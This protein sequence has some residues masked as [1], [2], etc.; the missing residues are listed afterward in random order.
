MFP[1]RSYS[2]QAKTPSPLPL[3]R[4]SKPDPSSPYSPEFTRSSH[5]G[6]MAGSALNSPN[7]FD[8]TPPPP[9]H[10]NA[11][12]STFL[13]GSKPGYSLV[14]ER[15]SSPDGPERPS[16]DSQIGQMPE[17]EPAY[18]SRQQHLD[19]GDRWV[20]R[21]ELHDPQGPQ[22]G[23]L[24]AKAAGKQPV[25]SNSESRPQAEA[26]MGASRAEVV[27]PGGS[28]AD[29]DLFGT[30][31][32]TPRA[33]M[34]R[35]QSTNNHKDES[36][37]SGPPSRAIRPQSHYR[38]DSGTPKKMTK[39]QFESLR[40]RADPEERHEEANAEDEP[41][42]ED[43]DERVRKIAAQRKRQEATMSVYRQQMK[44]MTG[45]QPADLPSTRPGL[46]RH[47]VSAPMAGSMSSLHLGGI[48]NEPQMN[49]YRS[50]HSDDEDDEVPLG[51]LQA[52]GFPNGTKPPTRADGMGGPPSAAPSVAGGGGGGALPAF[53]RKLPAD[54]YY[55]AGLVNQSNREGL[56]MNGSGSTYGGASA[57]P[58]GLGVGHP[59]G[60]VGVI[61]GEERAKAAR[62]ATPSGSYSS[63]QPLPS[64]M[65]Q[66]PSHMPRTMSMG[67]VQ[68]QA[69]AP[70]GM[71]PM[72]PMPGM[73]SMMQINPQDQTQAQ[74]QQL[75]H[76]QMQFMQKMMAMQN[77][78]MPPMQNQMSG[79]SSFLAPPQL[80]QQQQQFPGSRPMSYAPSQAPTQ[81]RAMTMMGPPSTWGNGCNNGQNQRPA[82]AMPG[83][84]A[85]SG[86]GVPSGGGPGAGYTPSIAPS[87][88]SN[89]GMPS[90]YRPVATN[91]DETAATGSQSRTS[92]LTMQA[93]QKNGTPEPQLQPQASRNT[94][95]LVDKPKGTPRAAAVSPAR[96]EEAEEDGG[97]ADLKKK[98]EGRK[99]KWGKRGRDSE[100]GEL[101]TGLE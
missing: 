72:P 27:S 48:G 16:E 91:S 18:T 49:G 92:S 2:R 4:N 84:Y 82:S 10:S 44:K 83:A 86:F 8:G 58:P 43:D 9:K 87:E 78:Q 89:V 94:V 96:D 12:M 56:A 25:T 34:L 77:G 69:Y 41:E 66:Q 29:S 74:M 21:V 75:M 61:A 14:P 38:T 30:E 70:S 59:G 67:N 76:M 54:P 57:P 7:T 32:S 17:Q 5:D 65:P 97:W 3:A 36:S 88:R 19:D 93:M 98:R 63:M 71:P 60:L 28:E 24:S 55:G 37:P 13:G 39:A 68:P 31:H 47:S 45:G 33:N 80:Q 95:R 26:A 79:T 1:P 101:Y 62:R 35:P 42:D 20:K 73:P 81:G 52:H 40:R 15:F 22:S 100:L 50:K 11:G 85:A 53:A 23:S 51:I 6:L 90:R 99:F 64:N 46:E